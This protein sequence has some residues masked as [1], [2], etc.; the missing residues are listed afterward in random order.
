MFVWRFLLRRGFGGSLLRMVGFLK[1][2]HHDNHGFPPLPAVFSFKKDWKAAACCVLFKWFRVPEFT[3]HKPNPNTASIASPSDWHLHIQTAYPR[4]TCSFMVHKIYKGISVDGEIVLRF[5]NQVFPFPFHPGGVVA[6]HGTKSCFKQSLRRLP[7]PWSH[8]AN[9][10]NR[11]SLHSLRPEALKRKVIHEIVMG[12]KSSQI[13]NVHQTYCKLAQIRSISVFCVSS[14]NM[15]TYSYIHGSKT[16]K[17]HVTSPRSHR[18]E[19]LCSLRIAPRVFSS[20]IIFSLVVSFQL[21]CFFWTDAKQ[22]IKIDVLDCE[23]LGE[24]GQPPGC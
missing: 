17:K 8:E 12:S 11:T 2:I 20:S 13:K 14:F 23:Y 3:N 19:N 9:R 7:L 15:V 21:R 24:T 4:L 5:A 18:K 1:L 6:K 16:S 10:E 22:S